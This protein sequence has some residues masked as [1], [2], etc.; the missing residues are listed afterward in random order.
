MREIKFRYVTQNRK[1]KNDYDLTYISLK[2]LEIN[3]FGIDRGNYNDYCDLIAVD[4]YTGLKDKNNKLIYENDIIQY[5]FENDIKSGT[6]TE[7]VTWNE[8][9]TGYYPFIRQVRFDYTIKNVLIIGNK[10]EKLK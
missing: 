6:H 10:Y 5:D 8:N 4:E 3:D 9:D 2:A 7:L 1:N